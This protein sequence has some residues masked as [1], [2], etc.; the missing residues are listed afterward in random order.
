MQT[1]ENLQ[2]AGDGFMQSDES[3]NA[4][5][6]GSFAPPEYL[7]KVLQAVFATGFHMGLEDAA[8]LWKKERDAR[9]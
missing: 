1:N 9:D 6:S 3:A 7:E 2:K 5:L 8:E 4:M